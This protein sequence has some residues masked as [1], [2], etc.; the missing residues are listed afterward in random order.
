MAHATHDATIEWSLDGADFAKGKYTRMHI[1]SFDGGARI[2]A[3]AAPQIVPMPYSDPGSVDPE[4]AFVAAIASCHM[5]WFLSL[6]QQQGLIVLTYLDRAQGRMERTEAGVSWV[7]TVTLR[8]KIQVSG[9]QPSPDVLA[10]LHSAAHAQCYIANSLKT[11][12]E[13][14]PE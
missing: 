10:R 3:S 4:E 1:W 7:S 14:L 6:A 8:P 11:C 12:I 9:D 2:P 5:L 13:I